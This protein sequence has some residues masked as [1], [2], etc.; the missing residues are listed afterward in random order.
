MFTLQRCFIIFTLLLS[1]P[2]ALAE[3]DSEKMERLRAQFDQLVVMLGAVQAIEAQCPGYRIA[4]VMEVAFAQVGDMAKK[5]DI[6]RDVFIRIALAMAQVG[7]SYGL[8]GDPAGFCKRVL[9]DFGPTSPNPVVE[10][11]RRR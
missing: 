9:A 10:R 8:K 4:P 1:A 3:T 5:A 7:E 2:C 6:L 11:T